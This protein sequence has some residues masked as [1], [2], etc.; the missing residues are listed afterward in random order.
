L[1]DRHHVVAADFDRDAGKDAEVLYIHKT[2]GANRLLGTVITGVWFGSDRSAINWNDGIVTLT[3]RSD[4][5][6]IVITVTAHGTHFQVNDGWCILPKSY[7]VKQ[8]VVYAGAGDDF[9]QNNTAIP[10]TIDGGSGNDVLD[11]GAGKDIIFGGAGD[12]IIYGRAG[13]DVLWGEAGIDRLIGGPGDDVLKG[14]EVGVTLAVKNGTP[15]FDNS[16]CGPNTAFRVLNYY[17]IKATYR[18]LIRDRVDSLDSWLIA[19]VGMGTKPSTM[20][21]LLRRKGLTSAKYVADAQFE[22]IIEQLDGGRPVIALVNTNG[23]A[24]GFHYIVVRGYD[25]ATA[26][27]KVIDDGAYKTMSKAEFLKQWNWNLGWLKNQFFYAAG[28]H[29]GTIIS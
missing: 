15:Q 14:G 26:S 16:T 17:G 9:V 3:G 11:G 19:N 24:T 5:D 20:E 25:A 10:S 21:S 18:Q 28:L 22:R 13:N 8:I 29:P 27:L 2:S 4:N 7:S 23:S 12:D 1:Y 6:K